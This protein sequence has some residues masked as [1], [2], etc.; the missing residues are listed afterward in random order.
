LGQPKTAEPVEKTIVVL[1]VV[2]KQAQTPLKQV[3]NT[4]KMGFSASEQRSEKSMT[5]FFNSLKCSRKLGGA[6]H[7]K[8]GR[9]FIAPTLPHAVH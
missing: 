5:G 8:E 9:D 4:C 6:R 7:K 2:P 1:V 3:R